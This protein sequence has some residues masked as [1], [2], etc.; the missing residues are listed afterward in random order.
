M[1][2]EQKRFICEKNT[3]M[4]R[5]VRHRQ[6]S[7]S[8]YCVSMWWKVFGV[9]A[10]P[11]SNSSSRGHVLMMAGV[12]SCRAGVQQERWGSAW[13]CSSHTAL[14]LQMSPPQ[15]YPKH[16]YLER[17]GDSMSWS[18]ILKRWGSKLRKGSRIVLKKNIAGCEAGNCETC[19][20]VGEH[21]SSY[22]LYCVKA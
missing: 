3:V 20:T 18:C 17:G 16:K 6:L 8:W 15:K 9:V 10:V 14:T 22:K 4:N 21:L 1:S 7:S 2:S 13:L 12:P 5:S 11:S 19:R